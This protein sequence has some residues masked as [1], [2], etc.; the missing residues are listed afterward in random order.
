M[1]DETTNT[2]ETETS[3]ETTN[4]STETADATKATPAADQD[5]GG[6]DASVL[7]AAATD[8]GAGDD[9]GGD[10][11]G[12]EDSAADDAGAAVPERYELKPF[13]VGE[14]ENATTFEI[15]SGLLETVTPK[16]KEAG[17]SQAQIE[18]LAPAV[19]P[20]IQ[21][22]VLQQQADAFATTKADWAKA[23]ADDPEIGGKQWKET[24]VLAARALDHFGAPKGSEFRQLL[25]ETGL[26]NHPVMIKMFRNVGA[27]LSEDP[28]FAQG[29]SKIQKK[30]REEELYPEDVPKK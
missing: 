7:G 21:K 18:T 20:E 11:K 8:D 6:E 22:Q 9:A 15:D 25:D 2:T 17:V 26:G 4:V 24:Q 30:S 3:T 29:D 10:D 19:V 1:A 23:A 5:A 27:A 28:T 13:T 14:G 12:K 16:L